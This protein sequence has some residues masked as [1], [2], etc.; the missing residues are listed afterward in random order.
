MTKGVPSQCL[1]DSVVSL[2]YV[3]VTYPLDTYILAEA[4]M[5]H[6]TAIRRA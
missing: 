1:Y 4:L 5:F 2:M 6:G 3:Y